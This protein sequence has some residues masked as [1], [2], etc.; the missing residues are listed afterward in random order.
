[1]RVLITGVNGFL[2]SAIADHLKNNGHEVVG[3]SRHQNQNETKLENFQ[4]DISDIGVVNQIANI[5]NPCGA[6]VHAAASLGY[7]LFE[8]SISL[9]NCLG[10]Q[11]ILELASIWNSHHFVFISSIQVIGHPHHLP[12]TEEHKTRPMTAYHASKLFGEHLTMIAGQNGLIVNTLRVTSP[13]GPRMPDNRILSVFIN[14]ALRN[15]TLLLFGQGTRKQ[16]YVDVRDVAS[17]VELCLNQSVPGLF[18]IAGNDHIS[19][20]DLAKLCVQLLVSSS[21]IEFQM[22]HDPEEGISWNVSI[23][24]AKNQLGYFPSYRLEDSIRYIATNAV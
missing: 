5:I 7:D 12:I 19:N 20:F 11:Q 2:G 1:M 16:N 23:D 6:I 8:P 21:S 13:I 3:L 4:I 18:N 22:I 10:T 9:T 15:E 17:S 24:K 14:K